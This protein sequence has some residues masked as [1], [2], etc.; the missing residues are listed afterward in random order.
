MTRAHHVRFLLLAL[1]IL[2]ALVLTSGCAPDE[3]P[4]PDITGVV[5]SAEAFGDTVSLR[6]I[7]TEEM[8]PLSEFSFDALQASAEGDLRVEDGTDA[9]A[10]PRTA[11]EIEVGD[12]ISVVVDGPVAESYPP[13]ARAG[14]ITYLGQYEGELPEAPGLEP[15]SAP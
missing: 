1:G 2:A 11:A 8:G 7:W 10:A 4:A 14:E 15:P 3:P 5:T 9:G 12:I 6:V 13:Q